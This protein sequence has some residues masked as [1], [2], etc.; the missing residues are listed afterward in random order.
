MTTLP[1]HVTESIRAHLREHPDAMLLELAR[2]HQVPELAIVTLIGAP[3]AIP[4]NAAR[5]EELLR[6]L[7]ALGTVRVLV[8]SSGATMESRGT[9]GGLSLTGDYFNVQTSTLD[10]HV[11]WPSI[12]S[13]YA[14]EKPSHQSRR[15][16]A[17]I[18]LFDHHGAATLKIFLLF[19]EADDDSNQRRVAFDALRT[20][21]ALENVE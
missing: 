1:L 21:F 17:S 14:I 6:S 8:S 12:A 16:T 2:T 13:V 20:R 3:R 10:L 19:G 11:R 7:P 15:P 9:F 18:Q 4:L 5:W